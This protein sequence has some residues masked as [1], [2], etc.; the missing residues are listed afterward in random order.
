MNLFT[1]NSPYY[2]LLK[3]L[4]FLLKHPVYPWRICKTIK[5]TEEWVWSLASICWKYTELYLH[6]LQSS[7]AIK[8]DKI[9]LKFRILEHNF[10]IMLLL[11][12]Q[13]PKY[14]VDW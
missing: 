7:H 12:L 13:S 8:A 4:L 9:G 2:H 5:A 6:A 1:L 14:V 10:Y 3:Y 11:L